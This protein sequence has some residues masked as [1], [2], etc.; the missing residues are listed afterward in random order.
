MR[1][2]IE[3]RRR[4]FF[5]WLFLLVFWAFNA[6]MLWVLFVGLSGNAATYAKLASDAERS[7]HAAGTAIGVTMIM[8]FWALGAVILGLA[9]YFTRGRREMIEVQVE[10]AG[11]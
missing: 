11:R 9:A 10:P 2:F 7:G 5:G 4:G 6:F 1:K 3:R 8:T